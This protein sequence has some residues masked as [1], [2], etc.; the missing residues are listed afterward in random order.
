MDA[1]TIDDEIKKF[2]VIATDDFHVK[3]ESISFVIKSKTCDVWK[4]AREAVE[5]IK[6]DRWTYKLEIIEE[7]I[8]DKLNAKQKIE[9]KTEQ[10]RTSDDI[11]TSDC[12]PDIP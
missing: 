5:K 7:S 4:N 12:G 1:K 6:G 3:P 9:I 8:A 11:I 2:I 10:R